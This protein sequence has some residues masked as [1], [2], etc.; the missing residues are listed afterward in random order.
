MHVNIAVSNRREYRSLINGFENFTRNIHVT[1]NQF[2]V[3]RMSKY[4]FKEPYCLN[5]IFLLFKIL[6][7]KVIENDLIS[8]Q[9]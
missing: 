6:T 2:L 7:I 8:L 9:P 5:F 3:G 4:L 1:T